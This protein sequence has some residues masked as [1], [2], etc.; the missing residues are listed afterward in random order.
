MPMCA[1]RCA[2]SNWSKFVALIQPHWRR[3]CDSPACTP[4]PFLRPEKARELCPI[5]AHRW[6][7]QQIRAAHL[8]PLCPCCKSGPSPSPKKSRQFRVVRL[9]GLILKD[10]YWRWPQR[11]LAARSSP[12]RQGAGLSFND[13]LSGPQWCSALLR[14]EDLTEAERD[15]KFLAFMDGQMAVAR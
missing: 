5:S 7:R 11:E 6:T 1:M 10:S 15:W 14:G 9:L 8:V 13:L 2:S 12:L 3:V 4:G